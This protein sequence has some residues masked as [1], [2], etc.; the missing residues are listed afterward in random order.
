MN[1]KGVTCVLNG[2]RR[3]NYV[4]DSLGALRSPRFDVDL[5]L[6]EAFNQM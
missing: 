1:T 5:H 6:Y 3:R 2:M 4:D